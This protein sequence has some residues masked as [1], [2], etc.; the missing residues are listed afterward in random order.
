VAKVVIDEFNL[1][2]VALLVAAGRELARR[3]RLAIGGKSG[4]VV[5]TTAAPAPGHRGL[6]L[7]LDCDRKGLLKGL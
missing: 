5:A 2:P 1:A 6:G 7:R 4:G 3:D